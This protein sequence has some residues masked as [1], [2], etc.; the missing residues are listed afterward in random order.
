MFLKNT[1]VIIL[2]AGL[3]SRMGQPKFGI[4]LPNGK[5]FLEHICCRY[6]DSGCEEIVA[7]INREGALGLK[8]STYQYPKNVTFTINSNPESGRFGSI[9]CGLA[10]LNPARVVFIHNVDNP[11]V[12]GEILLQ[13]SVNLAGYDFVKPVYEGRGGHPVLIS[14]NVIVAAYAQNDSS[15]IFRDFLKVF[16]GKTVE[17]SEDSILCN[18]NT[19]G[20]L[21]KFFRRCGG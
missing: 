1:S 15:T 8:M 10:A 14:K 17:V 21:D 9:L 7:V 20:D 13:M 6:A 3:S 2:A 19:P 12:S 5:T 16:N 4:I 11:F 18:I